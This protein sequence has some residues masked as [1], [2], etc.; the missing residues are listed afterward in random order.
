MRG[1]AE[2][3]RPLISLVV[4]VYQ[5]AEYLPAFLTSVAELDFDRDRLQLL[6]VD[7]GS[8]DD[9]SEIIER[10]I[11]SY[12]GN[13]RLLRK[14]NGG[15]S[16]AR[17]AGMEHATGTWIS[18]PDPDDV[19]SSQ[20]LNQVAGFMDRQESQGVALVA[21][22]LLQFRK[23]PG[24]L[25]HA[26]PLDFKFDRPLRVVDLEVSP[27]YVHLHSAT[28]FY[29]LDGIRAARLRFDENVRP[30]F[31]DGAFTGAYLLEVPRPIVAFVGSAVYFYRKREDESSLTGT[32][33]SSPGKFADVLEHG[34]LE[35]LRRAGPVS[36]RWLQ[37]IVLYDLQWYP[38]ADERIKSET[39][40]LSDEALQ[41]FYEV[42]HRVL[43]HMDADIFLQYAATGIPYRIRLGFVAI[44]TGAIPR[45]AA[46][47]VKLDSSQELM[48]LR[49]YTAS[50]HPD[51]QVRVDGQPA[52]PVYSKTTSINYFGR[53][54]LYERDLWV[55]AVDWVSLLVDG[56]PME[57]RLGG[58][59]APLYETRPNSVWRRFA[60]RDAP[61]PGSDDPRIPGALA[62]SE[63]DQGRMSNSG[64]AAASASPPGRGI[65]W[66]GARV[67]SRLA[68][69]QSLV[70]A[71]HAVRR[72]RRA[73]LSVARMLRP[74]RPPAVA[75]APMPG[76]RPPQEVV[77]KG[78]SRSVR[79]LYNRAWVLVDRDSMA[80][81]NAEA[82][83][84]YLRADQPQVN[85]WFVISRTSTDW[86]R[87]QRDGFRL[88]E[89]GSD[90]HVMLMKNAEYL[91]SSQIDDYIVRPFDIG[92]YG[93][94]RW[95]F[96]F[97]QHGVT[98]NDLSR[99]LNSKPMHMMITSSCAEHE[100]IVGD[101]S[102]YQLSEKEVALT[103]LPR[104]DRLLAKADAI[105]ESAQRLVLVMPTW[106]DYLLEAPTGGHARQ[107]KAGFTD[108]EY[109]RAWH[110]LLSSRRLR[111]A[112]EAAG[113][114]LS[115][116][117]HPNLQ[118][119]VHA[120][121]VPPHVEVVRYTECDI[122]EVIALAH[123]MVTDY[124]S[125]AFEAAY[126]ERPVVYFQFDHQSF[127]SGAHPFRRG[128]FR[129]ADDGFGPVAYTLDDALDSTIALLRP[130][131]EARAA[132]RDRLRNA[133]PYRDGKCCERV[134][135]AI[136]YREAP[137]EGRRPSAG[138][139]G[140]EDPHSN[141]L[142]SGK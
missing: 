136:T 41:R 113:L 89:Y 58:A 91:L 13:A 100:G 55:S 59:S 32:A 111:D 80:Q 85:A 36:P 47:V 138:P 57:I 83:Y 79:R 78:R 118:S 3:N 140:H 69:H 15:L 124:S 73:A 60:H 34:H 27:R 71:V 11:D 72:G 40:G 129:F 53:P 95:K 4:P 8:P 98:Y 35:L 133:F 33:W 130:H 97:L 87:L 104:H 108:S 126:I 63:N 56:E 29:R 1:M 45:Q 112:I 135:H 6:F 49:R 31:E 54:W 96:V 68:S 17:N 107:L 82:F 102:P 94:G 93:R 76:R 88:V 52:S 65:G 39:S 115:F 70:S 131:S 10:W 51:D 132:Y 20:Y 44:K 67:R 81:D 14:E 7:D 116:A 110:E 105:P 50:A 23:D 61:I 101:R 19:L 90:E 75:N 28:G 123:V 62:A 18:F 99:W 125:L 2:G 86:D 66:L 120:F 127:Y 128:G 92:L 30:V 64:A 142:G 109:V 16:S 22:R 137:P 141:S 106:R 139:L 74:A 12:D 114:K 121:G 122:Q 48:L 26:H 5:V 25:L 103:G 84:R 9:S 119:H 38:K 37:S 77:A 24:D 43:E 21:A 134:F 117:P 42:L 46:H